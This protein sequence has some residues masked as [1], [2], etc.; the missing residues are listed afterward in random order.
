MILLA[1]PWIL[2]GAPVREG[3][4]FA[5]SSS[6]SSAA[7]LVVP[8]VTAFVFASTAM[9][10][11]VDYVHFLVV[12]AL[13]LWFVLA[14]RVSA[15]RRSLFRR[16]RRGRLRGVGPGFGRS[17]HHGVLPLRRSNPDLFAS[18]EG[19]AL[20]LRR[21]VGRLARETRTVERLRVAFPERTAAESEPFLS[22]GRVEGFDVLW[23]RT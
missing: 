19:K 7:G 14:A 23:V 22:W 11:Q 4:R 5:G 1:L 10:F 8:V 21:V 17:Q 2:R 3:R 18:V 15:R 9:R 13:V 12:P 6:F 16:P 20:P